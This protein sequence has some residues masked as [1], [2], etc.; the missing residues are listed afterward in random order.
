MYPDRI[1]DQAELPHF[2]ADMCGVGQLHR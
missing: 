2:T 1:V